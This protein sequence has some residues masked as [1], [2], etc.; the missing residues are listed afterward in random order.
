VFK[1]ARRRIRKTKEFAQRHHTLVACTATGIIT[2]RISHNVTLNG[3]YEE[4]GAYVYEIGRE[5]G[6]LMLQNRVMLDFIN[7]REMGEEL[8]NHLHSMKQ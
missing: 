7:Q 5:N 3:V 8:R 2:W 4:A 1:K 6:H